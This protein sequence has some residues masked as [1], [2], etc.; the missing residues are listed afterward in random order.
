MPGLFLLFL[1]PCS[2]FLAQVR[3]LFILVLPPR[4][5]FVGL[6]FALDLFCPLRKAVLTT[7]CHYI[8]LPSSDGADT[9]K[10]N[11]WVSQVG[12]FDLKLITQNMRIFWNERCLTYLS[13]S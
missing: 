1:L 4:H 3:G 11:G 10:A 7:S 6:L 5:L 9:V 12:W 13:E 8:A 2:L